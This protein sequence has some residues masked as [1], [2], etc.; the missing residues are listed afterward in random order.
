MFRSTSKDYSCT[1]TW[2]PSLRKTLSHPAA[3]HRHMK[4]VIKLDNN[5]PAT[6]NAGYIITKSSETTT[7]VITSSVKTKQDKE[8]NPT[9]SLR[10]N[11]C[12]NKNNTQ[13]GETP[14]PQQKK[15][16]FLESFIKKTTK[17]S[18]T[19]STAKQQPSSLNNTNQEL[20]T[21]MTTTTTSSCSTTPPSI[22]E[23]LISNTITSCS[24][25]ST[26]NNATATTTA[27]LL[28]SQSLDQS[29]S[30]FRKKQLLEIEKL[31]KSR[32]WSESHATTAVNKLS[33]KLK[34]TTIVV[35]EQTGK[36]VHYHSG[37]G[38]GGQSS[39]TSS[40]FTEKDCIEE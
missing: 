16:N 26:T 10:Y 12:L 27:P 34:A 19:T 6:S 36:R 25:S 39:S 31:E 8:L 18:T 9:K 23:N 38:S 35:D 30:P 21:T 5:R 15:S 3:V 29:I 24:S 22:T 17:R 14:P 37:S 4:P 33:D 2:N 11:K 7:T 32:R 1:T 28:T 40:S 13:F 20:T